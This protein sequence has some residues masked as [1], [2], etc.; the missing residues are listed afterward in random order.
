MPL[1]SSDGP[2]CHD[3]KLFYPTR[4]SVSI[5]FGFDHLAALT[6]GTEQEKCPCCPF[7]HGNMWRLCWLILTGIPSVSHSLFSLDS[8]LSFPNPSGGETLEAA[9]PAAE[10]VVAVGREDNESPMVVAGAWGSGAWIRPWIQ[11]I[12]VAWR[13]TRAWASDR[14]GFRKGEFTASPLG[15]VVPHVCSVDLVPCACAPCL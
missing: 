9:D 14:I 2:W 15:F 6:C 3:T 4:H 7:S 11:R 1:K 5:M 8:S 10:A 13:G 12:G